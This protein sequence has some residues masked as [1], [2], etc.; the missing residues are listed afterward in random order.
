MRTMT[1]ADDDRI[2]PP[3]CGFNFRDFGGYATAD[4]GHVKPNLLF[5]AGVMAFVED[6]GRQRL[7]GL[8]IA[9]ICD[10]RSSSERGYRPTKWHE[11][12]PVEYWA[13]DYATTSADLTLALE[14]GARD[15]K[16]MRDLM[17]KLYRDIAYEHVESY[18]ALF[19]LM[20][21]GKVPLVVNCSAGKD[22]TGTA[23][24]LVLSALGVPR[25]TIMED[26]LL[27]AR[28][29][30]GFLMETTVRR[31]TPKGLSPEAAVPLFA[32]DPDYLDTLFD[33]LTLRN[34]SI[35][36][37]LEQELGVGQSELARL[38]SLLVA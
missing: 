9:A 36:G 28:A 35:A 31:H 14:N 1:L 8:G 27:T 20:L 30:F 33:A 5:R 2:L 7:A 23:V 4:G 16:A 19:G 17:I 24:A 15:P 11:G 10:L 29:D 13:R 32:A 34:G 21:G 22:R 12:L 6:A 37:Y 18:R 38:R 3:E 25:E 26:Y